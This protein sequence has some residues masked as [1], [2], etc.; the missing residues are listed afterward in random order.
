M[1]TTALAALAL[2]STLT[3]AFSMTDAEI[4]P[5]ELVGKT[6]VF[7]IENGGFPFATNGT[8]AG[9]FAASGNGFEV[10]NIDGDTADIS[11]TYTT[12]V[13][14]TFTNVALAK[15]V[16]G[17]STATLTLYTIDGV[18]HY[19][20][21]IDGVMGV[22]VNGT[23][24]FQPPITARTSGEISIKLNKNKLKD[25][26][27]KIGFGNVFASK[28]GEPKTI[29]IKNSGPGPLDD[30]DITISG[31]GKK[32]F[33]ISKL[34][35]ETLAAGSTARFKVTFK[36]HAFGKRKAVLHV[37]STDKNEGS[38]D[39]FLKGNGAGAK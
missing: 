24:T 1:K 28:S 18:G 31:M 8:W 21:A 29:V 2:V 10:A 7:D 27:S 12:T 6:L 4:A 34:K 38:F 35:K 30:L 22:S 11:T 13:D 23:F 33:K 20:V 39:I 14:G 32:D 26:K 16:E 9:T 15:F 36:P 5:A 17:K 25:G 3:A 37:L 19:E